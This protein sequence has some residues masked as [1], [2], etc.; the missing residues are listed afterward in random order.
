M[1]GQGSRKLF[2]QVINLLKNGSESEAENLCRSQLAEYPRDV[3]FL[4][5]LGSISL[6]KNDFATAEKSL[7][8]VAEIAPGY[9]RVQEDLGTVLLNMGRP[10]EAILPLQKA[11]EQNPQNA[12]AFFKLGGALKSLGRDEAGDAALKMASEL[13]PAQ[14]NLERATQLFAQGKFRESEEIAKKILEDNP[15]EVNAGLLLG[16]IAIHARA[17]KQAEK[18]LKRVIKI[19]PKFILAWHELS[20]ALREQGKDEE[21]IELLEEALLF[22]TENATTHYQLAAALAVAGRTADSASAYKQAVQIDPNLVGAYL[23]LGHTLKTMGDLEGGIAA[24]KQ[25]RKLKPNI[26]E[27]S[28]SLSNLKTFRFSDLEIED[29]KRRLNN[30]NLDQPSKVAFSFSLGKAYEDMKKYDEAFEFYSK[31]NEIHRSLVTYDPVQTEVS[32]EKLKEVFS[33]DFFDKLDSSKVG[34]SDPSPIFIVGMPRSGSTLLEQILASHSQVDGTREL[35]DLGIVSQ[36]LNNRER[37]TLYPGGI[38]K[39][40]PSEI[41]ELGKTY[42]DRAERHRA[43]AP[44]FTDKMPNNFAHIGLIATILPNAKIIDARRHPLDSCVGCFKQHWALGQ[45]YTYDMFELGEFYLEY[46]SLMSH[47]ESV[48]PGKVLRVQYEDVIDDLETQVRSVLSFCNLPFEDSCLNFHKTKR[49]VATASS[50]QVRQPIYN[51]SVNSWKR[52]ESQIEPLI[53]ILEPIL[54]TSDLTKIVR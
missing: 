5:L 22:D 3:N 45:T 52:F 51:K 21:A 4:S 24:Y 1:D 34:N 30:P 50:E 25:A 8:T 35:P 14:A 37:G 31:G 41:F 7:K 29:M 26:G 15:R 49:S 48:L 16:R 46:D 36:M 27:I 9:P 20:N 2:E 42:L 43:G 19:A 18:L 17:F 47:W 32:N 28:F 33:K 12:T 38:R 53:E 54:D 11:I 13:S 39:M 23:G 44:F 10:Q 6:R 40:K